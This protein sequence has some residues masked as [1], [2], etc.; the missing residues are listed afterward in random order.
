MTE[1]E[2]AR[3]TINGAD[4]EI[5]K[6]FEK[7]MRAVEAVFDYK[8]EHGLPIYDGEIINEKFTALRRCGTHP[9]C[10]LAPASTHIGWVLLCR[11]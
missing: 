6:L 3:E 9:I 11:Q 5:A 1:I 4:K 10:A 2:K 8:R 7:R